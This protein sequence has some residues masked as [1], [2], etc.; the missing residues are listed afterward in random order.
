MK[1]LVVALLVLISA[2]AFGSPP[3]SA[4]KNAILIDMNTNTILYE[5]NADERMPPASMSKIMAGYMTFEAIKAGRLKLDQWDDKQTGQKRSRLGV[6]AETVQ[7][8]GSAQGGG[9]DGGAPAPARQR[10]AAAAPAGEPVEGD[11]PPESDDVP[12]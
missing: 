12:F 6:I 9:N 8:L 5:K 4:A 7:F 10:P 1:R 11:G 3:D 2:P